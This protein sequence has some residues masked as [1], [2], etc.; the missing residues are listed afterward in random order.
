MR[1]I[2][3]ICVMFLGV[4]LIIGCNNNNRSKLLLVQADSLLKSHP[5]S[6][7]KLLDS[8][9]KVGGLSEEEWMQLIW[10][11]AQAHRW[12]GMS[13]TEDTLLPRAL[14]YYRQRNDSDKLLECYLLEVSYLRWN[15]QDSSMMKVF[16][17]GLKY[18][19][20]I[21]D[22]SA[23]TTF[24]RGK[25]E[26]ST[27]KNDHAAAIDATKKYLQFSDKLSVRERYM[28]TYMLGLNMSLINEPHYSDY[29]EQSIDM[30]LAA[31]DTASACHY[32]RNY[33]S[34]LANNHSF[35]KSNE[36][37][38]R[39]RQLMPVYDKYPILQVILS[40]NFI[41]LHQLDS[42][43]YYW[44]IAWDNNRKAETEGSKNLTIRGSLAQLKAILDYTSGTPLDIVT[45]GRFADSIVL[46]MKDQQSTIE[47]QLVTKNK[48]QQEN[49]E[50]IIN[51][52]KV[53]LRLVVIV[54]LLIAM[55][56]GLYLY[57]RNR[58]K[59]L[60]EAEESIDALT[61]LLNDAQKVSDDSEQKD[62][63][64]FFKKILLQQLGII[65][66][67]AG[68]PTSQNQSL[69]K[70]ISGI[71]NNEIP[72]DGLLVW[73]DLYPIIDNLY[74]GF[75]TRLNEKFGS[76]LTDKEVQICCL[77]CA[78]F[79]TKEIGVVTQQTSAT[80]YVRKSSIRKKIGAGEKQDIVDCINTI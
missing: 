54:A 59:R 66:L 8:I 35:I 40:E 79:S 46:E 22:T 44:N 63:D 64:A 69:L 77:L 57:L 74:D 37:L 20:T 30:A 18:A 41:N 38:Q 7:L 70:L 23:I 80:I 25:M 28:M 27:L 17:S 3:Y 48:L 45:F 29:Y 42:A 33:A 52:Q 6:T 68:A 19:Y 55:T 72:V 62:S 78:N 5:D 34:V 51:R 71:S 26:I 47:Q 14:E 4:M 21:K 32:M 43:R 56:A 67:V 50:L 10:N 76:L 53:K 65:R 24:Y 49:Y 73:V 15:K 11:R 9:E 61:R 36:L 13:M 39:A 1:N 16:D 75:Y 58:Q 2:L 60:A 31:G 12:L